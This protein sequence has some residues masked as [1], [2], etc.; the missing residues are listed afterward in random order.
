M[1]N[2][3]KNWYLAETSDIASALTHADNVLF[4]LSVDLEDLERPTL[5]LQERVIRVKTN[6]LDKVNAVLMN[7]QY[8]Q[9]S[10][11]N[12]ND[13]IT[14]A[15]ARMQALKTKLEQAS[16]CNDVKNVLKKFK[17]RKEV[18]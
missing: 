7:L 2:E 14:H 3:E 17:I 8:V 4:D 5:P 6:M 11:N 16:S 18:D 1:L 12:D 13:N 9:K 15:I 10:N